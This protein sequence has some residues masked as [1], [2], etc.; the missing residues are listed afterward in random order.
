MLIVSKEGGHDFF[1]WGMRRDLLPVNE[2][3]AMEAKSLS[4]MTTTDVRFSLIAD[5]A[6]SK[7]AP[8]QK[9]TLLTSYFVGLQE[10]ARTIAG[11]TN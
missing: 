4:A 10:Q 1:G 9:R 6:A 11:Q 8:C 7:S 3:T 2:Y 5:H